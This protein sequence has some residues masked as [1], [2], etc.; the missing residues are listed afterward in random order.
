MSRLR[1]TRL[2]SLFILSAT[3]AAGG[4]AATAGK[5]DFRRDIKPIFSNHCFACHGPDANQRE[6]DLRLDLRDVAVD[7]VVKPGNAAASEL[8][9]RV[10]SSDPDEQMPP[11]KSNKPRLDEKQIALLRQWI[12][13][14][15][16]YEL[17][18]S[19]VPPQRPK[20]PEVKQTAWAASPIDRFVAA[21]QES[22][23]FSAAAEADRRTL[24]RRLYFDLIGLP[25]APDEVDA[26]VADE[27]SDA[28]EKIVDRLLA[29]QHY[30]E[31]MAIYWLDLVRYADTNG[32]HGDN[33]R[34]H[35]PFRDY[36]IRAFNDDMPFDQFTIEQLAG[37]LLPEATMWQKVASGYNRLNM[38]TRE[39]GA[40]PK[41]YLA[42]YAADRVRNASSVW[43]GITLGCCEC[44]DHKF[45]P[46]TQKDFYSLAS[47]FVDVKETA[48]GTQTGTINVPPPDQAAR[49]AELE[50]QIDEL[51]KQ[52][53][54]AAANLGGQQAEWEKQLLAKIEAGDLDWMPLKPTE[55]KSSG[56]ATLQVQDD[57]S[58]LSTG[59]NPAKDDYTVT[60][61]TD[62]KE[63]AGLQLEALT[64]PS[65]TAEGLSR[66]NG[67][68]VLTRF[69]VQAVDLLGDAKLVKIAGAEADYEQ[70]TFPVKNAIDGNAATGWAVSG[71]EKK[72]ENRRAV[73]V[74]AEPVAGGPSTKLVVTM[75]HESQ[76]AQHNI[77]RFRLS[78][79]S[80]KVPP[81]GRKGIAP[82][83]VQLLKTPAESRTAEQKAKVAQF[84]QELAPELKSTRE[85]LAVLQNQRMVAAESG[86]PVLIAMAGPPREMRILPRG[87]WLDDSGPVVQPATPDSMFSL[88]TKEGRQSRLD[89]A[90]WFVARDNPLT[91]RVI[92]NRLWKICFGKGIVTTMDD[93]GSQGAFPTHPELL[94]W[95][96]VEFMESGWDLKHMIKTIVMSNAYRQSSLA[97]RE[98]RERDPANRWLAR[99]NRFRL[100]AEMVRDNALAV[101]GLLVDKIGGVSA[102][103]YQPVGYWAHLNFPQRTYQADS[104]ENQYRRG[105]YT[106]WCRTFLHPSLLAFD[107]PTREECCVERPRSN[108]PLQALVLL[109]DPTYVE[110]ARVF[111]GRMIREGGESA[112]ERI[113][114]AFRETLGRAPQPAEEKVLLDLFKKHRDEYTADAAAAKKIV[115]VGESK[116]TDGLD[117]VELAA[118]T[119]V[120]RTILNLH[121]TITRY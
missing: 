85:R 25:P 35:A 43:M 18:W 20:L 83:L 121:E 49:L 69:E 13:E 82:E 37:D 9:A 54:A 110:A 22:Q 40:Q 66:G 39:G 108:T 55:A 31:R 120:S 21:G 119:S 58:V 26:F 100:D 50:R 72:S 91:A 111:A 56:G 16:N 78:I 89:L 30:G 75:R 109:N 29:S 101:S 88:E 114:F 73:F 79:A 6:A 104:G 34:D 41:E 113:A 64:H 115:S 118:W 17:H 112:S 7:E 2:A 93:F 3:I 33:H 116:K 74:F 12:D 36:V 32:I 102:K 5:I 65:L 117:A 86:T 4:P 105:L 51:Q 70:N 81:L 38:T 52:I 19:F 97:S 59:E 96:A 14:G 62:A 107:A 15:A 98:L 10:T 71:H 53:E 48:V 61:E 94:D 103:P 44:H 57:L 8:I 99:Q 45:D 77:G 23:G 47:F 67:N 84:H 27:S 46:F 28:Y 92:V 63:I 106:Y 87:N 60:L 80:G 95:L 11:P 90:K 1:F 42:K 24:I 68:F 76:F